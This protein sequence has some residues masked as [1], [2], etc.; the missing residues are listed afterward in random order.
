MKVLAVDDG[1]GSGHVINMMLRNDGHE[2]RL[3]RDGRD[4]YL[5]YLLSSPDVIITG[6]EAAEIN[7]LKLMDV[8]RMDNPEV[9]VIYTICCTAHGE[10]ALKEERER[11]RVGVL[12]KPFSKSELMKTLSDIFGLEP[13]H[14]GSSLGC[15]TKILS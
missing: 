5:T 8:I 11:P 10:A 14:I 3:A 2:I 12:Q 13:L 6:I 7:G 4:A 1:K 9:A 15:A